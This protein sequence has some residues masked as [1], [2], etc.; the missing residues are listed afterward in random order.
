MQVL[1]WIIAIGCLAL[2][3]WLSALNWNV[4]WKR[5]VRGVSAPS[6]IPLLAGSLGAIG[7]VTLPVSG[8]SAWWW[9]PLLLD[10]GSL[11][12]IGYSIVYHLTRRREK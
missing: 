5:H 1:R 2:A 3:V 8:S 6:W 11:P 10:W 9:V 4:F 12:G 7:I